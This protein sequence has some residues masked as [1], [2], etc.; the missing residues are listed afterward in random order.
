ML[1]YP[2]QVIKLYDTKGTLRNTTKYHKGF[3][4]QRIGAVSCLDFHPT[5]LLLA[6]GANNPFI[7][8]LAA[9]K[10]N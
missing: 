1:L 9:V 7:S 3:M 2:L 4:G 10:E 8:L 5:R 6:A